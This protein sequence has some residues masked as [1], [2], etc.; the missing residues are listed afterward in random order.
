LGSARR[1]SRDFRAR[2]GADWH[3]SEWDFSNVIAAG[4]A[5]AHL[6]VQFTRCRGD[7]FADWL[8]PLAVNRHRAW[9]TLGSGG[10]FELCGLAE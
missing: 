3:H 4:P 5:K 1:L 9:G 10:S 7:N 2:A 6:D 8:V